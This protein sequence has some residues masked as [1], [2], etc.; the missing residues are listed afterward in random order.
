MQKSKSAV[1]DL[2]TENSKPLIRYT[3]S[4]MFCKILKPQGTPSSSNF[5]PYFTTQGDTQVFFFYYYYF[6]L[7]FFFFFPCSS[8]NGASKPLKFS[9]GS[10]VGISLHL[11]ECG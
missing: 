3:K 9:H 8:Q 5:K 11:S 2:T 1:Q 7:F 6:S 4:F 10:F